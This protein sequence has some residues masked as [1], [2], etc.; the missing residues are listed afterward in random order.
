MRCMRSQR[1]GRVAMEGDVALGGFSLDVLKCDRDALPHAP[2]EW[3]GRT[4]VRRCDV[5]SHAS[6]QWRSKCGSQGCG[7]HREWR[8]ETRSCH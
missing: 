2:M 7:T 1:V 4:V 8:G 3:V 6:M 5:S